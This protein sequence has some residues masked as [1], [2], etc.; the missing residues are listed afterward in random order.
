MVILRIAPRNCVEIQI[1]CTRMHRCLHLIAE[2][3]L[4]IYLFYNVT[5]SN[6]NG[7]KIIL[8]TINVSNFMVLIDT[9]IAFPLARGCYR[10][11]V[12]FVNYTPRPRMRMN[13]LN[14][15]EWTS[16]NIGCI[17]LMVRATDVKMSCN[18]SR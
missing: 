11:V 6:G 4:M 13:R 3:E 1:W 2:V 18:A 15:S 16:D 9:F 8:L 17:L 14:M 5:Q 7:L 10:I 12:S